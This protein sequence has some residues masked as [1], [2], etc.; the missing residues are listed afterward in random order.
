[1]ARSEARLAVSIWTDADFLALSPTA[2]RMFMFLI[3]QPDLAHDGVLAL[4]ERRW[5]KKAAGM[6]RADVER[7]LKDLRAARFIVVDEDT[8]EML[9]RSFIRR[10]KV[11]RQPNVLRSAADHLAV[12]S[13]RAILD[14]LAVELRRVLVADDL[15]EASAGIVRDMIA[16]AEKGSGNPSP[17]PSGNPSA[18]TPGDR[19]PSG[20][21]SGNPSSDPARTV[22]D[23]STDGDGGDVSAGAKG[24]GNPSGKGSGKGSGN[25]S[26]GTPGERGVVTAVSSASPS[27][28]PR[29]A[30]PGPRPQ[31]STG[32]ARAGV[33]ETPPPADPA[34]PPPSRCDE[35]I[36]HPDPPPC[37]RCADA[38][39]ARER[40]FQDQAAA[41]ARA[42]SERARGQAEATRAAI[43]ACRLCDEHGQRDGRTCLHD[44]DI[45]TRSR[46]G[47]ELAAAAIRRPTAQEQL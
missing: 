46:R 3:S 36:D 5:S 8:E 41:V 26:A 10:D 33:R 11:Y 29:S 17:N 16:T 37:G 28:G 6:T 25:P 20:N 15:A 42:Q 35:H 32:G 45:S 1:M 7:D 21:P 43:D 9:I 2:Q 12:V 30:D 44:P 39:R 34:G 23:S 40:Y 4:R 18:G 31:S 19:N 13:S 38:R 14:A 22:N 27:P 24:S 47:A